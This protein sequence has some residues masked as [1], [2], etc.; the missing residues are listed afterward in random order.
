[1]L[2]TASQ[3]TPRARSLHIQHAATARALGAGCVQGIRQRQ[4]TRGFRWGIWSN[5]DDEFS[6]QV[7]R[8]QRML[9]HRYFEQLNRR[10]SWDKHPF[11]EHS[12]HALKRMM[13]SYWLSSYQSGRLGDDAEPTRHESNDNRNGVR[14]G[15]N[16]ED[17]ERGA[18]DHLMFGEDDD[19]IQPH[20]F[21]SRNLK[22]RRIR[23]LKY[24]S[25]S[26]YGQPVEVDDCIID[27]I[28]NRKVAKQPL[29]ISLND[30]EDI[31]VKTFKDYRSQS[32]SP[33]G[34]EASP[35]PN[36]APSSVKKGARY[37][38]LLRCQPFQDLELDA[39]LASSVEG[40]PGHRNDPH[41]HRAAV[42]EAHSKFSDLQPPKENVDDSGYKSVVADEIAGRV[43][44]TEPR[45]TN[46]N[47]SETSETSYARNNEQVYDELDVHGPV[48]HTGKPS[49]FKEELVKPEVLR[50]YRYSI[51]PVEP[52]DFP[53]ST[54]EGLR[55]KYGAAELK[56]Y[57]ALRQVEPQNGSG[58]T[59]EGVDQKCQNLGRRNKTRLSER[60]DP[61]D[62]AKDGPFAVE[63]VD[64]RSPSADALNEDHTALHNYDGPLSANDPDDKRPSSTMEELS[65]LETQHDPHD[66][67]HQYPEGR[68]AAQL[69]QAQEELNARIEYHDPQ[70]VEP[71]D[72][73]KGSMAG[74]EALEPLFSVKRGQGMKRSNLQCTASEKSEDGMVSGPDTLREPASSGP[75]LEKLASVKQGQGKQSNYR[76]MLE[77]R[78]S[79]HEQL[80]DAHDELA[81]LAIKL[82]KAKTQEVHVPERKFT[83][84]YIRDFPE[85]FEKSWTETLSSTPKE[86]ETM[87]ETETL[88]NS[89]AMDGGLEGAFGRPSP[90]RFQPALDRIGSSKAAIDQDGH[91]TKETETFEISYNKGHGE[92]IKQHDTV[93][94]AKSDTI[95]A[96]EEGTSTAV[97]AGAEDFAPEKSREAFEETTSAPENEPVLYKILAYD[98]TMQKINMAETTSL[99]PDFTSALSP[100]DALLRLSHP[101]RFFPHFAS[102]EAEGFEIV[103]GSGDVLV[104]RKVRP[105]RPEQAEENPS[106]SAATEPSSTESPV[107]PIDMT[108]RPRVVSP[109]SA[110]FASP[111]G[112]VKYENLPETEASKLPPPPP[113][114]VAYNI[115]LRREE[116]VYSG[117]KQRVYGEQKQK[118]SVA[119]RLLVGGAWVA[120]ISYG[121]GVV[122]EYFTTGGADG[123][124]P[125]GL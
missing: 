43:E 58:L 118:K 29:P 20:Q 19:P 94:D 26:L 16:I 105:S 51:H 92:E 1:M 27:P 81:T 59:A 67:A 100:A 7:R 14:P 21:Q 91:D 30:G 104:F 68:A 47:N 111:T 103:S 84:N 8:Q 32:I 2:T 76:G 9:K 50:R 114:R 96:I 82:A 107:N 80:S 34:S 110:N 40:L 12:R 64:G 122:S 4:Q 65:F 66:G 121:L 69:E 23:K 119:Q 75:H 86:A 116:P 89:E 74:H 5:L 35:Q 71:G 53:E 102:L 98:P 10:L 54:A 22:R 97:E 73:L 124:G 117:P 37:D 106:D 83:G 46:R 18:M 55:A 62:A 45:C 113:P 15:R 17:V 49:G 85:E 52:G 33:D 108:G 72:G 87:Y 88:T 13:K 42:E 36:E 57:T 48:R 70:Q 28:T 123:M 25:E 39:N 120:G 60:Y 125:S 44:D 109:A 56:Q 95:T 99:V 63:E 24:A 112:Y 77:S 38:D 115:N 61:K 6:Q 79:Q 11:A 90:S 93:F 101:T 31:P 78:M 41:Q 3:F